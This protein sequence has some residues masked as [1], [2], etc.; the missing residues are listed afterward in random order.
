MKLYL[1]KHII[2]E[3]LLKHGTMERLEQLKKERDE[4]QYEK[5]LQKTENLLEKKTKEYRDIL[6]SSSKTKGADRGHEE[7]GVRGISSTG[8]P[9]DINDD[10]DEEY[11]L[12]SGD[13]SASKIVGESMKDKA[14][15]LK[16]SYAQEDSVNSILAKIV[17]KSGHK[18]TAIGGDSK[19]TNKRLKS[20]SSLVNIFQQP[21]S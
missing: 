17:N 19:K 21:N 9:D 13:K 18:R 14:D 1:K 15:K 6:S 4:K 2:Q 16:E 7:G 12:T 5:A 8:Q 11:Y 3:A 20:F 10:L